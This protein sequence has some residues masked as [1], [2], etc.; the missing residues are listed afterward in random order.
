MNHQE[1]TYNTLPT[2]VQ[3]LQEQ[4]VRIE[5]KLDA[6]FS[7]DENREPDEFIGVD[8]AAKLLGVVRTTMYNKVSARQIPAYKYGRKLQFRRSE[9]LELLNASR[10]MTAAERDAIIKQEAEELLRHSVSRR[11][12][13]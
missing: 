5:R 9:I 6:L 8:E 12:R 4:L 3:Q 1:V 2:A 11:R 7:Y 10:I 13:K